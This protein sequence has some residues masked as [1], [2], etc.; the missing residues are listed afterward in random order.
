MHL[1]YPTAN[2]GVVH[3]GQG[4]VLLARQVLQTL[5]VL[6]VQGYGAVRKA[7]FYPYMF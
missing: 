5:Q 1:G 2:V 7:F 4:Q 3:L 6:C